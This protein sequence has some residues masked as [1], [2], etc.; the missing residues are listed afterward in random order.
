MQ[1]LIM[2]LEIQGS[3]MSS[4]CTLRFILAAARTE[5]LGCRISQVYQVRA[6]ASKSQNSISQIGPPCQTQD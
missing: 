2:D 1:V 4:A 6:V 5:G 3:S